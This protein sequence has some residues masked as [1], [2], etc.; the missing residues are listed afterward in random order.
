MSRRGKGEGSIVLRKDGRWEAKITL[1]DGGTRL[2]RS[3]Y[4]NSHAE[5]AKKLRI[6]QKKVD[7]NLPIPS[8]RETVEGFL[9]KWLEETAKPNLRPR[10]FASYKM[11][12][13]HHLIPVLGRIRLV[14]LQPADVRQYVNQKVNSGLSARSVQYHHAVLRRALNQA[15]RDGTVAR[16]VARL[17]SPPRVQRNEVHPLT[18]DQAKKLLGAIAADRLAPLYACAIGL[19]LR[20]GEILGLTWNDVDL[21]SAALSVRHTL[22]RYDKEYHLDAPKTERSRRTLGLPAALVQL[23]RAH[24]NQQLEERLRAGPGWEGEKWNLVFCTEVGRPMPGNHLTK[25]FQALLASLGLPRQRFHD[26][27]HAAA[28]YMLAQGVDLRVVMEVLGHSQIHVTANTYAHVR[29]D[30][31]RAAAEHVDAL[32]AP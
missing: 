3:F 30:L 6:A 29:I 7:D 22:Q 19:G 23:L 20:Q 24:R 32:L 9:K 27:R 25:K 21:E 11:I 16:N 4:G 13:D 5:V 12:V 10:T 17:V 2:R 15:E 8:E 31:T 18:P 26:L 28:T 1:N 14:Q